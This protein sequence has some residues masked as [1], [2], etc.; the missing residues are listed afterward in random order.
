MSPRIVFLDRVRGIAAM[1]VLAQHVLE[2]VYESFAAWSNA[3]LNMGMAGVVAFFLVSG[4]VITHTGRRRHPGAFIINRFFRIFPLYWMVLLLALLLAGASSSLP[5]AGATVVH[6]VLLQDYVLGWSLVGG[7]WTLPVELCFYVLFVLGW[8]I[9]L[10]QRPWAMPIGSALF[11]LALALAGMLTGHR[12]PLGRPL[13]LV[14]ALFASQLYLRASADGDR[15]PGMPEL[16]AMAGIIAGGLVWT[17]VVQGN[18]SFS[19]ACILAS[20][21][22]GFGLFWIVRPE[23]PVVCAPIGAWLGRISYSV[24][25]GQG[26]VFGALCLLGLHGGW[27]LLAIP[28]TVLLAEV[29]QRYV[30]RPGL[31]IGKRL[32]ARIGDP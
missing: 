3:H 16:I 32:V 23:P 15:R 14:V 24:Y 27:L 28:C 9:R 30:E 8:K 6:L 21:T 29:L 5:H 17:A 19:P 20:W 18:S 4:Y 7:S 31:A 10:L 12:M 2:H 26:V 1:M 22:V 25:L 13:L 11:I